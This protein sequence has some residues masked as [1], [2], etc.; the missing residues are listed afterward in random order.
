MVLG[1]T[2]QVAGQPS[3]SQHAWGEGAFP[4]WKTLETGLSRAAV[5][6]G[7]PCLSSGGC[8]SS[9]KTCGV[10]RNISV[11][12][13][14]KGICKGMDRK[15]AAKTRGLGTVSQEDGGLDRLESSWIERTGDPVWTG[16]A[17]G[18]PQEGAAPAAG[19]AQGG[20]R[21]LWHLCCD[22]KSAPLAP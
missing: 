12:V 5:W 16:R 22:L 9:A 15:Q 6:G 1:C 18:R 19:R 4:P 10:L 3:L 7:A 14:A 13:T 20:S 21:D 2:K 17:L 8:A 11:F